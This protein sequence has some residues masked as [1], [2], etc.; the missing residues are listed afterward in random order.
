[1]NPVGWSVGGTVH[2]MIPPL[3]LHGDAYDISPYVFSVFVALTEKGLPFEHRHLDIEKGEHL[4]GDYPMRSLTGRVPSLMHGDVALAESS[5]ILEYLEEAFPA[6][7]HTAL[8]PREPAARGRC[9]QLLSWIRSDDTLPLREARSTA[10]MFYE[11][12]KTPLEGAGARSAAKLLDVATRMGARPG[13]P[14]FGSWSIADAELS[15]ILHRLIRNGDEV[16]TPL[17][18]YAEEQWRRPSVA[19]FV[20]RKRPATYP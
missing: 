19:T 6:P 17:R 16:P 13:A 14:L 18:V 11:R 20:E 4:R 9:R 2:P 1:M 15:F 3:V 5:A 12:A 10:T 7:A 8:F